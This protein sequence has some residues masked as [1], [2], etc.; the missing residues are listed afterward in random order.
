M[1]RSAK[2]KPLSKLTSQ[3]LKEITGQEVYV[4]RADGKKLRGTL[5]CE[6]R[7]RGGSSLRVKC[8][9]ATL[10]PNDFVKKADFALSLN[11]AGFYIRVLKT[12]QRLD[13]F[14]S[15][16]Q[17]SMPWTKSAKQLRFCTVEQLWD[18]HIEDSSYELFRVC[19]PMKIP[20][21]D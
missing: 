16:Q 17:K 15:D 8:N 2:P 11:K 14:I 21:L 19:R 1:H 20:N 13:D 6:K 3:Q 12:K 5:T 7:Q 10:S 9:E 18:K 4:E